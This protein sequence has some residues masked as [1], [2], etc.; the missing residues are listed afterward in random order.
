MELNALSGLN[1]TL[2]S[3]ELQ[4][5]ISA[6]TKKNE[7]LLRLIGPAWSPMVIDEFG[8]NYP[9]SPVNKSWKLLLSKIVLLYFIFHTEFNDF[10]QMCTKILQ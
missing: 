3:T 2:I 8:W 1:L 10:M 9:L 4:S 6:T 5:A 7:K